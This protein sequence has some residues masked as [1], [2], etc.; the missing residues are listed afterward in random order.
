MPLRRLRRE[1]VR[2][3]RPMNPDAC[4]V[5][6]QEGGFVALPRLIFE[7]ADWRLDVLPIAK[8]PQLRGDVQVRPIGIV[9]DSAMQW[10]DNASALRAAIEAKATRY[11]DLGAPYVVAV[12]AVSQ[13]LH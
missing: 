11:A 7:H 10:V 9:G 2:F 5:L 12:N 8:S 1:V 13:H 3:L 4:G 6:L